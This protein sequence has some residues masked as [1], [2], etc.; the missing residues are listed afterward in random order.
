[1]KDNTRIKIFT[2]SKTEC[3]D[4]ELAVNSWLKNND[5]RIVDIKHSINGNYFQIFIIIYENISI[6]VEVT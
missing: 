3:N 4:V 1:M 5:V 6:D 2:S